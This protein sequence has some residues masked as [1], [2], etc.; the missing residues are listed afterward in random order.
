MM[1][2]G[3]NGMGMGWG[4]SQ[5]VERA[6]AE[7]ETVKKRKY[8]IDGKRGRNQDNAIQTHS[9]TNKQMKPK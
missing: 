4:P 1:N 2:R 3:R 9:T 8:G 7:I 6:R 5:P